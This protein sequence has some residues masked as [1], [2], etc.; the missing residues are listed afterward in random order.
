[1]SLYEE[2]YYQWIQFT[3]QTLRDGNWRA[4]DM[5]A[6]VEEVEDL[7]RREEADLQR[8]MAILLAHRLKWQVQPSRQ[9]GTWRATIA[10]Q[11]LRLEGLLKESPSL[12]SMLD[13]FLPAAFQRAILMATARPAWIAPASM[14]YAPG[15]PVRPYWRIGHYERPLHSSRAD[16]R[17]GYRRSVA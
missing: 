5:E 8:R 9:S 17:S 13:E 3:A 14:P 12:R 16:T 4:I 7:G 6:L 1:M 10:A 2:D 15:T 11:R